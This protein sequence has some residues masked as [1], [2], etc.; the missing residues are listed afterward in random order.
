MCTINPS[1]RERDIEETFEKLDAAA[2]TFV[3]GREAL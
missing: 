2:A 1:T 3:E